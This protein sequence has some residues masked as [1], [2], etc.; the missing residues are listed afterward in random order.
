MPQCPVGEGFRSRHQDLGLDFNLRLK[1]SR[2]PHKGSMASTQARLGRLMVLS[3]HRA[4][5]DQA[6]LGHRE[7]TRGHQADLAHREETR[8]RQQDLVDRREE[9]RGHQEALV[10]E[11]VLVDVLHPR[12]QAEAQVEDQEVRRVVRHPHRRQ[13]RLDRTQIGEKWLTRN[14]FAFE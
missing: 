10:E 7:E 9:A 2:P 1:R 5:R 6:D 3:D 8:G 11:E 4:L 12:D 14:S 13:T